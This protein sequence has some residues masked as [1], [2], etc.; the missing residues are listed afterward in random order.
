MDIQNNSPLNNWSNPIGAPIESQAILGQPLSQ[1]GPPFSKPLTMWLVPSYAYKEINPSC[2]EQSYQVSWPYAANRDCWYIFYTQL[3]IF[4][5]WDV[6]VFVWWIVLGS[7]YIVADPLDSAA[8][9]DYSKVRNACAVSS[10]LA[11]GGPPQSWVSL[12]GCASSEQST[13]VSCEM[14]IAQ[15]SLCDHSLWHKE[16]KN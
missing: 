10:V 3:F 15:A 7:M 16:H 6:V 9:I 14:K 8:L 4:Q 1:W 2:I 12:S 11:Y 13:Q 5:E